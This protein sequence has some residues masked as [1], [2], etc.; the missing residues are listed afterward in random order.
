MG[1]RAMGL[2]VYGILGKERGEIGGLGDG[3]RGRL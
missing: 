1:Q 3:E 2:L